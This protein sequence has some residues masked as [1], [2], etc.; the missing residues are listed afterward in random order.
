[1]LTEQEM[2]YVLANLDSNP[3]LGTNQ[4]Y[5]LGKLNS[6]LGISVLLFCKK[7]VL[8]KWTDCHIKLLEKSFFYNF[9]LVAF[10]IDSQILIKNHSLSLTLINIIK[11]LVDENLR[12][13]IGK[14]VCVDY[15]WKSHYFTSLW[16]SY[17]FRIIPCIHP[18][19]M[20]LILLVWQQ[21][22]FS[23]LKFFFSK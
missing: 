6:P 15:T 9:R 2:N 7:R 16:K 10:H 11:L 18:L 1:M 21:T 13:K 8:Y 19:N 3:F 22:T 5:D 17:Y 4:M 14:E 12:K 20:A 23:L